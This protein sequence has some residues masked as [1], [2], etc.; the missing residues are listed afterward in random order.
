MDTRLISY[1]GF[2]AEI[3]L[4][5]LAKCILAKT[6][7]KDS[8]A[9]ISMTS[10]VEFG[11]LVQLLVQ[12]AVRFLKATLCW[13]PHQCLD[14]AGPKVTCTCRGPVDSYN[15]RWCCLLFPVV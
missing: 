12:F 5:A 1:D 9:H 3:C 13:L 6:F 7:G 4:F 15:L 14:S 8:F 2:T 11:L 10:S